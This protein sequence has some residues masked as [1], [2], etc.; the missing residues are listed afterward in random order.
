MRWLLGRAHCG[1]RNEKDRE[2]PANTRTI[3][4]LPSGQICDAPL[5]Y[6][7]PTRDVPHTT[8]SGRAMKIFPIIISVLW[9]GIAA[10]ANSTPSVPENQQLRPNAPELVEFD[11]PDAAASPGFGT[12]AFGN[13]AQGDIVG[14]YVDAAVVPH[15]FMRTPSG[16]FVSIDAPGAGLGAGLDQGTV[17]YAINDFD[18]VVGQYEDDNN[19]FHG[20]RRFPDGSFDRFEVPGAGTGANL[21]TLA[22]DINL[23]G[24]VA[25]IYF[26]EAGVQ[27]GFTRSPF[28]RVVS[29]DPAVSVSTLVCEDTCLNIEGAITGFYLDGNDVF[30]GF[31]RAPDGKITAFDGPGV[32]TAQFVGTIGASINDGGTITGYT[33][34]DNN[35]AHGFVRSRDG[36]FQSFDV[37]GA[38]TAAGGGTAAFSIN[39]AGDVTGEFLDTNGAMH[40]FERF[41]DGRITKFDAPAA[42]GGSGQGTRPSTNNV[43]ATVTGWYIDANN[44][45]H[46]FLWK[47]NLCD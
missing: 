19:V 6:A 30:P 5:A 14:Y 36:T 26:D 13:N 27:H 20:F 41:H 24:S 1:S 40:G 2:L 35:I 47:P 34:D 28:G 45:S 43:Q 33:V 16:R 12:F 3:L 46:G 37:P 31:V 11:A 38:S 4:R 18:V 23:E 15:A 21:G 39:A 25:G 8:R 9:C 7:T 32:G 22:W 17:A 42:G 29:F 44:V 10:P